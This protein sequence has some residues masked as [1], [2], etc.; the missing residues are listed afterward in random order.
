MKLLI[1]RNDK[2]CK[3]QA[4]PFNGS[5]MPRNYLVLALNSNAQKELELFIRPVSNSRFYGS[6]IKS[7]PHVHKINIF[8]I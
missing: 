2:F 1:N 3:L 6:F 8:T 4:M 5:L 7:S